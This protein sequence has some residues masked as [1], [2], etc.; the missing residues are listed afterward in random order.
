MKK[1][2]VF[3]WTLLRLGVELPIYQAYLRYNAISERWIVHHQY[4]PESFHPNGSVAIFFSSFVPPFFY[5]YSSS[6]A[7]YIKC[8]AF[9]LVSVCII[10]MWKKKGFQFL[11]ANNS[12]PL[13]MLILISFKFKR[14]HN[15]FSINLRLCSFS[16]ALVRTH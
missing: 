14:N 11:V 1:Y 6:L 2:I 16:T 10:D 9:S 15:K 5:F 4:Q 3:S 7:V 12:N 13:L 8:V